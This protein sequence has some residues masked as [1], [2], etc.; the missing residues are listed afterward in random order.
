MKTG[1]RARRA[2][3]GRE[4]ATAAE[5]KPHVHVYKMRCGCGREDKAFS[6]DFDKLEALAEKKYR[7]QIVDLEATVKRR[8]EFIKEL[9]ADNARLSDGLR[10]P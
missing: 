5:R 4:P 3:R 8:D 7:Q 6:A 10:R 2:S 9:L 1:S